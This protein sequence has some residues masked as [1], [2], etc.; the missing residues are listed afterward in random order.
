[1]PNS[2]GAEEDP[3]PYG[4]K[5]RTLAPHQVHRSGESTAPDRSPEA[6]V[7]TK[8]LQTRSLGWIC[9]EVVYQPRIRQDFPRAG[10][11]WTEMIVQER[12]ET[13]L[14]DLQSQRSKR[15]DAYDSVP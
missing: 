1:M 6:N 8:Q 4:R 11:V 5:P 7:G 15:R 9:D 10:E 12:N 3:V 2:A 14:A 13:T